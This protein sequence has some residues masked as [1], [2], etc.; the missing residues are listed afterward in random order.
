MIHRHLGVFTRVEPGAL[1]VYRALIGSL[2]DGHDDEHC[3]H[4]LDFAVTLSQHTLD[5]SKVET[6]SMSLLSDDTF[7]CS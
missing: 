2:T 5:A 1:P 3:I 6:I 7:V 4:S